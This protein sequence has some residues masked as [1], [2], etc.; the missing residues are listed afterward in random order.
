MATPPQAAVREV[1]AKA[2]TDT[3]RDRVDDVM[4]NRID[5]KICDS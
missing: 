4:L 2:A 1:I 5:V 3:N